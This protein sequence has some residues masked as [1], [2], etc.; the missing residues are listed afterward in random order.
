MG[1]LDLGALNDTVVVWP[2]NAN[3]PKLSTNVFRTVPVE[4]N[5]YV[6]LGSSGST[7]NNGDQK[8]ACKT[9][10]PNADSGTMGNVVVSECPM[11]GSHPA[12]IGRK[13]WELKRKQRV[14]MKKRLVQRAMG[15][16]H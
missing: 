1:M 10:P 9:Y 12:A 16:A 8:L 6:R 11:G 5:W 3:F 7:D 14:Q 4:G 15:L 13:N 2:N